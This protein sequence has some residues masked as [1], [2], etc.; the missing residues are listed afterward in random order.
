VH[1]PST[2]LEIAHTALLIGLAHRAAYTV[3]LRLLDTGV[4][5]DVSGVMRVTLGAQEEETGMKGVEERELLYFVA[6]D[7]GIRVF[8]RGQ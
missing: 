1:H 8:E 7:G 2:P 6:G 5:R 3:S 4:A